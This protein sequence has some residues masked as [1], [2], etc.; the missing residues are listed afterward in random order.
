MKN[1]TEKIF[2]ILF[3]RPS[4]YQN[5]SVMAKSD[6]LLELQGTIG[7]M[8]FVKSRAY[9]RH[10]RAKRGTYKK[11]KLNSAMKESSSKLA[12][13]NVPAKM[14][15]DAIEPYRVKIADGT[16]WWRLISWLRKEQNDLGKIDFTTMAGFE[17]DSRNTFHRLLQ[18]EA[19]IEIQRTENGLRIDLS[20]DRHPTFQRAKDVDGYKLTMIG[21]FMDVKKRRVK[22]LASS[23]DVITLTGRVQNFTA[24]LDIPTG[25]KTYLICVKIE[26]CEKGVI[27][28]THVAKGLRVLSAGK[29]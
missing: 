15:K 3:I 9:K 4:R 17:I 26:G 24:D 20:Y 1:E 14:F 13:A 6:S 8:T 29:L 18:V 28:N 2:G 23:S 12:Q 16:L 7:G 5:T 19:A 25:A 22:T 11:A 21:M 27:A 10:V